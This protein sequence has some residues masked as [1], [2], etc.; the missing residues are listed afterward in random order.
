[1]GMLFK[2]NKKGEKKN[3]KKLFRRDA[4]AVELRFVGKKHQTLCNYTPRSSKKNQ[5]VL[6][7]T[8]IPQFRKQRTEK[9]NIYEYRKVE[10]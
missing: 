9:M 4:E 1:M 10:K 8:T 6:I 2:L 5:T 7:W 3:H